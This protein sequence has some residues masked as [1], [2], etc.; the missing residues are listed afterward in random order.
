M[1]ILPT[2]GRPE[3]LQRFFDEGKPEQTGCIVI[4]DDQGGM[5]DNVKMPPEWHLLMVPAMR[6]FVAKCNFG[7]KRFPN[8]PWYAFGGDDSIGRTPHWDTTLSQLA[9]M[10]HV[11]WGNDLISGQCTQPF[12]YGDFVRDVGWL[13]N[14]HFKHL[15]VDEIWG[16]AA[17]R[18]GVGIYRSDIIQEN[19]HFSNG[20]VPYDQT[21]SE[22]MEQNDPAMWIE[23]M[24]TNAIDLIAARLKLRA[25]SLAR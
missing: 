18:A 25:E 6:G 21:A 24:R 4:D 1:H 20:K 19:L 16:R 8:E 17:N 5:Y 15:Y 7:F 14:P 12:I 23:F 2:R 13:C 11:V 22:R 3:R 9:M 10:G